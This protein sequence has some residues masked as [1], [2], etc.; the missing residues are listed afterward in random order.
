MRPERNGSVKE[1]GKGGG[2]SGKER[3]IEWEVGLSN[4]PKDQVRYS[5]WSRTFVA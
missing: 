2:R 4:G 3:S 5:G 1:R